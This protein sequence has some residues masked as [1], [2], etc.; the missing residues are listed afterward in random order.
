[1]LGIS[2]G[3]ARRNNT[4]RMDIS[5]Y[6]KTG[7]IQKLIQLALIQAIQHGGGTNY[8]RPKYLGGHYKVQMG[9]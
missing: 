1:M 6:R 8:V 3:H 7:Q 4:E 9:L 2:D 5:Y